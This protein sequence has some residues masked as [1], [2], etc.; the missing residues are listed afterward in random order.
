MGKA[1]PVRMA[2]T[3]TWD[4]S[5]NDSAFQTRIIRGKGCSS[6]LRSSASKLHG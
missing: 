6:K 3:S 1:V 5:W 4:F 2:F